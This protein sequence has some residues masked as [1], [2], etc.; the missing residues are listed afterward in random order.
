MTS[1]PTTPGRAT[2][3]CRVPGRGYGPILFASILLMVIDCSTVIYGLAAVAHSHVFA[4]SAHYAAAN[5]RAW[6]WI[7]AHLRRALFSGFER[8]GWGR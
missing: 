7:T 3:V 1:A 6:G 5:L 8:W 2:T 4:A